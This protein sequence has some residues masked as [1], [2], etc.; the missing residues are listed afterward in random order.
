MK[1]LFKTLSVVL[2]MFLAGCTAKTEY[3]TNSLLYDNVI[4][5]YEKAYF[6]LEGNPTVD[7]LVNETLT[8]EQLFKRLAEGSPGYFTKVDKDTLKSQLLN[9]KPEKIKSG[10]VHKKLIGAGDI[11]SLYRY[12]YKG[13]WKRFEGRYGKSGYYR[14]SK[15]F[16]SKDRSTCMII[17]ES[18]YFGLPPT[19]VVYIYRKEDDKWDIKSHYM[20]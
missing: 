18:T 10:T 16:F 15:P 12:G 9:A 3:D 17:L 13:F 5:D 6:E 8:D 14:L 7:Y 19:K 2:C 4:R 20:L 11:E 1:T